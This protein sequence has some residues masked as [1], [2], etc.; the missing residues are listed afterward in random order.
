MMVT[1]AVVEAV[2]A[3]ARATHPQECCGLLYGSAVAITAHQSA[4]NIHACPETHFEIDPQALIDAHRA[5]RNGG[6]HVVGYYH[7]HPTGPPEPSAT[8]IAMAAED[9][10]IWVIVAAG[11]VRL[12]RAGASGFS[13][14][15]YTTI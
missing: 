8:D 3:E 9:G 13:A 5:M 15:S 6:P 14:L 11:E 12:W 2:R 10:M 4:A 1:S 7:S